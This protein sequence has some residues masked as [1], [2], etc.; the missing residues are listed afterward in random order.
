MQ[1][2]DLSVTGQNLGYLTKAKDA[3]SPE[4]ASATSGYPLP[5]ILV[6]GLNLTF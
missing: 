4:V 3:Y 2:L 5:K 6:L 1:G